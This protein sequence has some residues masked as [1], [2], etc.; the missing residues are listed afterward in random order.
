VFVIIEAMQ[1]VLFGDRLRLSLSEVRLQEIAPPD[2]ADDDVEEDC[3][4]PAD[5]QRL[6]PFSPSGTPF[7][8]LD[9]RY[10]PIGVRDPRP[11]GR[12]VIRTDTSGVRREGGEPVWV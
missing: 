8:V 9:F 3:L 11:M 1:S 12:R 6:W 7:V 5:P 10:R 2:D 4:N